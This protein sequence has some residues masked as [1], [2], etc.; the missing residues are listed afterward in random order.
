MAP[1][2][3]HDRQQRHPDERD[4]LRRGHRFEHVDRNRHSTTEQSA[5][6]RLDTGD[7][8]LP[9]D[10]LDRIIDDR[11]ARDSWRAGVAPRV[12]ERTTARGLPRLDN[13]RACGLALDQERR[14]RH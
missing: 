5:G 14:P 8:E 1:D 7:P 13:S 9:A 4:S 2:A 3:H 6:Q 11:V 10:V 12:R